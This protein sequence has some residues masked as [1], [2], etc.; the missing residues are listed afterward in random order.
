[1][2]VFVCAT[3]IQIMR[4]VYMKYAMPEFSDV[5]D[6]YIVPSFS[7][8]SMITE[9]IRAAGLFQNVYTLDISRYKRAVSARLLYGCT[10]LAGQIRSSG[11]QK[12]IA[13]NIESAF[14]NALYSK[15]RKNEHFEYHYVEDAPGIY[16]MY[17]PAKI[18]TFSLNGLLGVKQPYYHATQYWFSNP[19]FMETPGVELP[20]IRK[21]PCINLNDDVFLKLINT[22]FCYSPDKVLE[23][24]DILITEESFYTDKKMLDNYDYAL[25]EEIRN[26]FPEKKIAVK[27]H[28]R[29]KINRFNSRFNIIQGTWIP[30]ELYVMNGI[31]RS[32][33]F[34]IQLG[35]ACNTLT[36]DKFMFDAESPKIVLAPL[37]QDKITKFA[38]GSSN[39]DQEVIRRFEALRETYT[40]PEQIVIA[41][42]KN[43]LF[44]T[45]N[46]W[47]NL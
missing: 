28:P 18:S 37:F 27:L 2:N 17:A 26:C 8:A 31:R 19:D 21:L 10:Q 32:S 45:L 36:S 22:I 25:F 23:E 9:N 12:I 6:M 34:P 38:D 35:I 29:T 11:Y 1:M 40:V 7:N 14:L 13:F 43:I 30:W 47:L 42:S 44:D 46:K 33:C 20:S 4:A 5:A 41:Y 39:V 15:N 3:P 24:A 16:K